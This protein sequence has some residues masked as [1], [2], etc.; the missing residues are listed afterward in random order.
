MLLFTIASGRLIVNAMDWLIDWFNDWLLRCTARTVYHSDWLIHW[1]T[2]TVQRH[3]RVLLIAWL[4]DWEPST[5]ANF[6]AFRSCFSKSDVCNYQ[7]IRYPPLTPSHKGIRHSD[8]SGMLSIC[9]L[10]SCDAKKCCW[11]IC[12]FWI[13]SVNK[14][15]SYKS[16]RESERLTT[17]L[18]GRNRRKTQ[19]RKTQNW[20]CLFELL[21]YLL[22][23]LK[24][25]CLLALIRCSCHLFALYSK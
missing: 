21:L 22:Q 12:S 3:S 23:L 19:K 1:L 4:I 8:P 7:N 14:F 10:F 11:I 5:A 25:E 13:E 20:T 6:F 17:G 24:G 18:V 2:C 16:E 9:L 15:I